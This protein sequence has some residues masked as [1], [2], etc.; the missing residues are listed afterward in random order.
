VVAPRH[1]FL[2]AVSILVIH[3]LIKVGDIVLSD[4]K[5]DALLLKVALKNDI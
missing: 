3:V 1:G 2:G 5:K 4:W